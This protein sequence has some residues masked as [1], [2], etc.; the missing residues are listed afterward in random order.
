MKSAENRPRTKLAQLLDRPMARRILGQGQVRPEAVTSPRQRPP[1]GPS[2]QQFCLQP[3]GGRSIFQSFG[4]FSNTDGLIVSIVASEAMS[5]GWR[6]KT[7][8]TQHVKTY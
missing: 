6:S 1:L 5:S 3:R 2:P 4:T 8:R 7:R